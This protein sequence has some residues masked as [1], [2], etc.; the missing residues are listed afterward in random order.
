MN[1]LS[2]SAAMPAAG[3]LRRLPLRGVLAFDAATCV[4]MGLLLSMW[5]V[6]LSA[7]LGLPAAFL[8]GAGLLLFPCAALMLLASARPH[9]LLLGLVVFGNVAW[10]AASVLVV[11]LMG[12]AALGAV[13]VLGQA[14]VVA[15]L[16]WVE[17]QLGRTPVRRRG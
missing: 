10:A 17:W 9:P 2:S 3:L 14:V 7:L 6:P 11:V 15:V 13:F 5:P 12:P 16:A 1:T 4:L 8:L